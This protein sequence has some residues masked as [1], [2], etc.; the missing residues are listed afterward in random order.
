MREG[1]PEQDIV[2]QGPALK[3]AQYMPKRL[4][5]LEII[6]AIG[7]IRKDEGVLKY[8]APETAQLEVL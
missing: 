2:Q 8:E 1:T 3:E 4:Q 5:S 6:V 7:Q